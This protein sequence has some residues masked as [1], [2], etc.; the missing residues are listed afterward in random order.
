MVRESEVRYRILIIFWQ[1]NFLTVFVEGDLHK[2]AGASYFSELDL[3]NA[4]C[5]IPLTDRAKH[6]TAFSTHRGLI[7]FCRLPFGLVT[8]SSFLYPPHEDCSC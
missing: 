5:Q 3:D 2:F 4:Y 8:A 6:L 1:L 7:E